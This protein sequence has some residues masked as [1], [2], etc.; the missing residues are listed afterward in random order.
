[1][2]TDEGWKQSPPQCIVFL[3]GLNRLIHFAPKDQIIEIEAGAHLNDLNTFLR[4]HGFEIPIGL[5]PHDQQVPIASLIAMDLP[6]WNMGQIG[7]WRDLVLKMEIMLPTGELVTS[8]ANVVKSV[9]G[10]DLH[11]LMIGA[12][13][14]LGIIT[15]VTLRIFPVK[16]LQEYPPIDVQHGQLIMASRR[17]LEGLRH[18]VAKDVAEG[19]DYYEDLD[20]GLVLTENTGGFDLGEHHC[21]RSQVSEFS[22]PELPLAQ[23]KLMLRTKQVFDPTNKL[24]PGEFG[25][26]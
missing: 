20:N 6:H 12:R 1:M 4:D 13:F 15:R 8:G 25:F 21:W 22:V 5:Q 14:T 2:R 10:Y 3:D 7:R 19:M 9:S 11:K 16:P 18:H 24:N 23:Q 17:A 26:L